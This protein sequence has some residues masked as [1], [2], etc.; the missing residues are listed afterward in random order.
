MRDFATTEQVAAFYEVDKSVPQSLVA[1]HRDEFE[2]TG[3][4]VI[5]G[6]ELR[7]LKGK[8]DG[9]IKRS[10]RQQAAWDRRAVLLLGMLLRDSEVAKCVR[11][12]LVSISMV[13][14]VSRPPARPGVRSSRPLR[15]A[16]HRWLLIAAVDLPVS[17]A[18]YSNGFGV[19]AAQ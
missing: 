10:A 14:A 8:A 13:F 15:V 9:L 5:T 6:A 16:C 11:Q 7:Q 12:W 4:R 18:K 1:F 17:V 2:A 19:W 3:Y